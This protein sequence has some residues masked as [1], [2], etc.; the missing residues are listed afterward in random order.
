LL[1]ETTVAIFFAKTVAG[2]TLSVIAARA[3]MGARGRLRR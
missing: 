2:L 3:I 1:V